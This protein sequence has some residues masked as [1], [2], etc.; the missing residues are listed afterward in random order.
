MVKIIIGLF[1]L[2]SLLFSYEITYK[3]S[4]IGLVRNLKIYKNPIW[5]AE[6]DLADGKKILFSSPKGMFEF[7]HHPGAWYQ[8][9]V[10]SENDFKNMYVT[11][12]KTSK[13][14]KA[15]GAFYVFGSDT[16][17]PGGDDLVPF[18]SYKDAEDFSKKHHGSK[19]LGFKEVSYGLIKLLNGAI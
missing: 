15:K 2:S 1:V 12:F 16:T 13:A 3:K 14:V 8:Y 17:S 7:Y 11:D 18:D 6:I 10:K 19:I 5:V 4:D 9:H